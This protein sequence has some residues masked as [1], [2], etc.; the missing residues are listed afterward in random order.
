MYFVY[1]YGSVYV[2][3]TPDLH[4]RFSEHQEGKSL[5]TRN[6]LPCEL[7]AYVSLQNRLL[8]RR[9]EDY[10]KSGSG[11]AFRKKRFGV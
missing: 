2:G 3:S 7:L 9:F 5:S 10:L 11:R 1:I 4:R 6:S 8:A